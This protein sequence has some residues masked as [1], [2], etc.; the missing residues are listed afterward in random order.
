MWKRCEKCR[1]GTLKG[2]FELTI[3]EPSPSIGPG[4][5]LWTISF[6]VGIRGSSMPNSDESS[7]RVA[8][9]HLKSLW[10]PNRACPE[11]VLGNISVVQSRMKQC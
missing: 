1:W 9:P 4:V 5:R 2:V 7:S 6:Q 3:Y 11:Q 10:M 8:A